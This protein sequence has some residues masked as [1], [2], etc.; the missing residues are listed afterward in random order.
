MEAVTN[1]IRTFGNVFC[2][3]VFKPFAR[4]CWTMTKFSFVL[5][6]SVGIFAGVMRLVSLP[7]LIESLP[8]HDHIAANIVGSQT[9]TPPELPKNEAPG[10]PA[11]YSAQPAD[12]E[13]KYDLDA[14]NGSFPNIV[15]IPPILSD[16][17][18]KK[19]NRPSKK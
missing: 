13:Y 11:H 9:R 14:N 5:C 1:V 17:D 8:N 3:L 10:R 6:L 18:V 15:E 16:L 19:R 12:V 4:F 7:N 2:Y